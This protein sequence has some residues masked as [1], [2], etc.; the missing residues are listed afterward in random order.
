MNAVAVDIERAADALRNANHSTHRGPLDGP[1]SYTAVG[2]LAELAHRVPQLLDFLARS[3]RRAHAAE[4]Y[5]DR[6]RDPSDA[7]TAAGRAVLAARDAITDAAR[8]LDTAHNH[9]GHIGRRI[10]ED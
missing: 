10:T 8:H 4:Q 2:N 3:L 6:G 5:D 1:Q 9:L 7:L